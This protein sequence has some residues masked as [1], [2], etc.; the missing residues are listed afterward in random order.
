MATK[1]GS[2][3][4]PDVEEIESTVEPGLRDRLKAHWLAWVAAI[5]SALIL[6]LVLVSPQM[7]QGG[8]YEGIFAIAL[9][10]SVLRGL[11]KI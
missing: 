4:K 2:V 1:H 10:L 3:Y 8:F 7:Q 6:G 9:V 11:G 5:S